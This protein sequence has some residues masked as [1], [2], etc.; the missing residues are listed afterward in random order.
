MPSFQR[1]LGIQFFTGS[2]EE[3]V[4]IGLQG[5]LVAVPAAP[6]LVDL[7]INEPYREALFNADLTITDSA[8]MVLLWRILSGQKNR[9]G[10]GLKISQNSV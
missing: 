4:Q 9:T 5:G 2:A 1:I 8:F 3:A 6:A 7:Q 10:V